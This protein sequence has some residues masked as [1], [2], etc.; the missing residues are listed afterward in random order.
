MADAYFLETGPALVLLIDDLGAIDRESR[1]IVEALVS[2]CAERRRR[3]LVGRGLA[4]FL[5]AETISI[6]GL[7]REDVSRLSALTKDDAR[8]LFRDLLA[9]LR[10]PETL[11]EEVT[12]RVGGVPLHVLQL[13]GAVREE[14]DRRGAIPDRVEFLEQA[15][16]A[17]IE[18]REWRGL[19]PLERQIVDALRWIGRPV[20][21]VELA[22]ALETP[23]PKVGAALRRLRRAEVVLVFKQGRN[24]SYRLHAS[25]PGRERNQGRSQR[26]ARLIHERVAAFLESSL[27]S[28]P[29]DRENLARH[30]LA[31]GHAVEGC[32]VALGAAALLREQGSFDRAYRLLRDVFERETSLE[33]RLRL[34]EMMSAIAEETGD[35][36]AG[37]EAILPLYHALE[38]LSPRDATRMR[39]CL[40]IHYHRSGEALKALEVFEGAQRLEDTQR[41]LEDAIFIDSELAEIYTFRAQYEAAEKA[42]HRGIKRL[43]GVA[44]VDPFHV[45]MQVTLRASL[46]H[47]EM[48]RMNLGRARSE[49]TI[50][51]DA[52]RKEGTTA[53]L[54]SILNNLGITTNQQNDFSAAKRYFK[55]AEQL[56]LAAGERRGTIKVAANLAIIDAKLGERHQAELHLADAEQLLPYYRDRRLEFFVAYSRGVMSLLLGDPR[57]AIVALERA[58]PL[59]NELGD[60]HMVQYGEVYLAEAQIASGAYQK[61]ARIL[62]E[63]AR[64]PETA[65]GPLLVRMVHSRAFFLETLL[66]RKRLAKR[67][68][69]RLDKTP[70]TGVE[71][72]EAWNDVYSGLAF[73]FSGRAAGVLLDGALET[74]T[75]L[76]VPFG[77]Q[78][79]RLAVLVARLAGGE[80]EGTRELADALDRKVGERH[81][82]LA[83]AQPL[84]RAEACFLARDLDALDQAL[85][86]ASGAIVGSPF[87][88]LDWRIELMRSRLATERGHLEDARRHL[89]RS[90]HTRDLLLQHVPSK[91]RERYLAHSRFEVLTATEGRLRKSPQLFWNDIIRVTP[92][93]TSLSIE[94]SQEARDHGQS[95]AGSGE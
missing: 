85:S 35:H 2:V 16:P 73:V 80:T 53:N 91:A 61:A 68:R 6:S 24:S 86:E 49:L 83:V 5:T 27:T 39:R 36:N 57:A 66:G 34:A 45:R 29:G 74:F 88:E 87:L 95:E 64:R 11:V 33:T 77:A 43:E 62:S 18:A 31:A 94:S 71:L 50:A 26:D 82:F 20:R 37:I 1:V 4:I 40:G 63:S 42:C 17:S 60:H 23:V 78:F 92:A 81:H 12:S 28:S 55:E 3:N 47:L 59:G 67:A 72:L 21:L 84:A 93:R 13:A 89:H 70:R 90:L 48:R 8:R 7:N 14:W 56:L 76:G 19:R 46:G 10:A 41:D 58:L 65:A 79:A 32:R 22:V 52:C 69:D 54:A 75:R 30:L 44:D 38:R 15:F 25:Q 51:L 9:P